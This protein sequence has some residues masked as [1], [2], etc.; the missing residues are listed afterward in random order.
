MSEYDER[1][2]LMG[3][4]P[5]GVEPVVKYA[6]CRDCEEH[7]VFVRSQAFESGGAGWRCNTCGTVKRDDDP[8]YT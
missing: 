6:Y 4:T 3:D 8:R 5:D 7:L 1:E 2:E